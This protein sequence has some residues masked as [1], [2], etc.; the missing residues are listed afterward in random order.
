MYGGSTL[1]GGLV[2]IGR[3]GFE[4]TDAGRVLLAWSIWRSHVLLTNFI[5]WLISINGGMIFRVNR[6]FALRAILRYLSTLNFLYFLHVDSWFGE[7]FRSCAVS[8]VRLWGNPLAGC[9]YA[10]VFRLISYLDVSCG[11]S[12]FFLSYCCRRKLF[13]FYWFFLRQT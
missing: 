10:Y 6:G 12:Y 9:A 3:N 11:T 5:F 4:L 13:S 2:L 8:V 1:W 7:D